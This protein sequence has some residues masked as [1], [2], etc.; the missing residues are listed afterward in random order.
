MLTRMGTEIGTGAGAGAGKEPG[1]GQ[2]ARKGHLEERDRVLGNLVR[3]VELL[4]GAR[5]LTRLMPEVRINLVY[6]LPDAKTPDEVAGIAG[7][8]TAV[9]G[10]IIPGGYPAFGASDHMA[11]AIIELRRYDT[12]VRAGMN[13]K[14]DSKILKGV[15]RYCSEHGLT[16]GRIDR[17]SEPEEVRAIDGRSMGWKIAKALVDGKV[18]EIFYESEGWGK[19][20][21]FVVIGGDA[22]EVVE[23]FLDIAE[24]ICP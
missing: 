22:V 1:K 11:R 8:I 17:T 3:A 15:E 24:V 14:Y 23:R 10:R 13:F 12:R 5:D 18:P 21:L 7:R 2:E 4:E 20:P 19:E 9:R 16:L 6:A